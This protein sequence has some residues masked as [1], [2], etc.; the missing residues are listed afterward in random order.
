M[1]EQAPT[2]RSSQA[3]HVL[4]ATT[5]LIK[6]SSLR[7]RLEKKDASHHE[8]GDEDVSPVLPRSSLPVFRASPPDTFPP[9][10]WS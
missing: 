8:L 10:L 1:G 6:G 4:L 3:K 2:L 9:N 5:Q 7:R